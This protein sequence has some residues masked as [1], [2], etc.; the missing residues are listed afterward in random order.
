MY[1]HT[2]P[3]RTWSW[4][5]SSLKWRLEGHW[6][7]FRGQV[8]CFVKFTWWQQNKNIT[9]SH[10]PFSTWK[11]TGFAVFP[12]PLGSETWVLPGSFPP[13]PATASLHCPHPKTSWRPPE[14]L[15]ETSCCCITG[16]MQ[17]MIGSQVSGRP[18]KCRW[19]K[20]TW[21]AGPGRGGR[22]DKSTVRAW[23]QDIW[24]V[25]I[26]VSQDQARQ[27]LA[28]LGGPTLESGSGFPL[29]LMAARG[30]GG[31]LHSVPKQQPLLR[32]TEALLSRDTERRA[33]LSCSARFQHPA[34]ISSQTGF[35][36]RDTG[37]DFPFIQKEAAI[38]EHYRSADNK[39]YKQQSCEGM[40]EPCCWLMPD[41]REA[42]AT[43]QRTCLCNRDC[44]AQ[45]RMVLQESLPGTLLPCVLLLSGSRG[46]PHTAKD[47]PHKGCRRYLRDPTMEV[48]V[49]TH[50]TT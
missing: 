7:P 44:P 25:I 21:C 5:V 41:L 2:V 20:K 19:R 47:T 27:R 35:Y 22:A 14:K 9:V 34:L 39:Y 8:P 17:Q 18:N 4:G 32:G 31:P 28:S 24:L 3:A 49:D 46:A 45:G 43:P 50:T 42:R 10:C 13:C 40:P 30:R 1:G 29:L 12:S 38:F 15:P 11:Q 16:N 37:S 33:W 36:P 48:V 6:I 23:K 26:T